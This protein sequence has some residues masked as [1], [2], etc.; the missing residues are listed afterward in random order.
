MVGPLTA[1]LDT[2]SLVIA[3]VPNKD[4]TQAWMAFA[5]GRHVV[6][7]LAQT[8]QAPPIDPPADRLSPDQ[9]SILRAPLGQAGLEL[10][11]GEAVERRLTK[12]GHVRTVRRGPLATFLIPMPPV[13]PES[14]PVDNWQTERLDRRTKG[15][16]QLTAVDTFDDHEN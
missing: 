5:M 3:A 10:R 16:R 11:D 14:E 4:R 12:L 8:F 9:F 6:V 13:F 1:I 15:F 7:D 2:S